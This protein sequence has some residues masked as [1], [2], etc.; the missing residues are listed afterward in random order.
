M[1]WARTNMTWDKNGQTGSS[2]LL[3]DTV[4]SQRM[5]DLKSGKEVERVP[6]NLG[7]QWPVRLSSIP[8]KIKLNKCPSMPTGPPSKKDIVDVT[9]NAGVVG[10]LVNY[11]SPVTLSS[12]ESRRS[13]RRFGKEIPVTYCWQ[14]R[15]ICGK[16]WKSL[17]PSLFARVTILTSSLATLAASQSTETAAKSDYF[18]HSTSAD[19]VLS[20]PNNPPNPGPGV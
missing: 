19:R 16:G 5:F 10:H 3:I 18:Q 11:A 8:Q 9:G 15:L 12:A 1:H 14:V 6:N 7:Q 20:D 17:F 4:L 2:Y 13:R